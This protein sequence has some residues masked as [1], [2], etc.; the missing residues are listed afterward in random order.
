[1]RRYDYVHTSSWYEHEANKSL[2]E[3]ARTTSVTSQHF[4]LV[5]ADILTR[6]ML[7]AIGREGMTETPKSEFDADEYRL[8]REQDPDDPPNIQTPY[9]QAVSITDPN[10]LPN[11][12]RPLTDIEK[13]KIVGTDKGCDHCKRSLGA[14]NA[15]LFDHKPGCPF[16]SPPVDERLLDT[17]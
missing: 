1:M 16:A 8:A 10:P 9:G 7:A 12:T 3:A 15:G 6:L 11:W 4:H 13:T 2:E 5:R 14:I 17:K